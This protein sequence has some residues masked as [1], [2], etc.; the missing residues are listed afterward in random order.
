MATE[1]PKDLPPH[2]VQYKN[3]VARYTLPS[4]LI[5]SRSPLTD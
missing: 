5:G 2:P 3:R 1:V 4:L